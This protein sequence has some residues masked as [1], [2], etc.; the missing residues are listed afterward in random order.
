MRGRALGEQDQ[1]TVAA[2]K[3]FCQ[4][5]ADDDPAT[6]RAFMGA[7]EDDLV[8]VYVRALG[9]AEVMIGG[10]VRI[11]EDLAAGQPAARNS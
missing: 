1:Q 6:L 10:L 11:I 9:R 8:L 4:A 3:A 5:L 2:A 7:P